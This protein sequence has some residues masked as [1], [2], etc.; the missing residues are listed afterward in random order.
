MSKNSSCFWTYPG[1]CTPHFHLRTGTHPVS[2]T[3][4]YSFNMTK[5][6]KSRNQAVLY[7]NIMKIYK[8]FFTKQIPYSHHDTNE[9]NHNIAHLC[10]CAGV[11]LGDQLDG[12]VCYRV[13]RWSALFLHCV[14]SHGYI[15][16]RLCGTVSHRGGSSNYGLLN[17]SPGGSYSITPFTVIVQTQ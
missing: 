17:E 7:T 15:A 9:Y 4:Y 14:V 8:R 13:D 6:T 10:G 11:A 16:L 2:T 3:L 5:R 12:T 1:G